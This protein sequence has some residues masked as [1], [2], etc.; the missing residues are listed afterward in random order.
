MP[1]TKFTCSICGKGAPKKLLEHGKFQE[2][3]D[4]LRRH[5]AKYHPVAHGKSVKK[6]VKTKKEVKPPTKPSKK[7]KTKGGMI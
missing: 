7:P 6:T 5:R 4:W 3:M 1:L 2:R